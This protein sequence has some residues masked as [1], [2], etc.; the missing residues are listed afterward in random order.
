MSTCFLSIKHCLRSE[1]DNLITKIGALSGLANCLSRLSKAQHPLLRP[2]IL[3]ISAVG[4]VL[5]DHVQFNRLM[6]CVSFLL[7]LNLLTIY[8]QESFIGLIIGVFFI[9]L[10]G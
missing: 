5:M 8:Y 1:N 2:Y 7:S 10:L 9:Y 4:G 3:L 6:P